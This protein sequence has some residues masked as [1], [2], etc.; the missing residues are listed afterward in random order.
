MEVGVDI[1]LPFWW[2]IK[3][4][5][6]GAWEDAKVRF[7]S[8]DCLKNYTKYEQAEF[9]LTWDEDVCKNPEARIVGYVSMVQNN[10]ENQ[11]PTK[12]HRYLDIMGKDLADALPKHRAYDCR[13]HLKEGRTAPWGPI[14]PLS[15][16]ELQT[17]REWLKE[18]EKTA[19][20]HHSTS[21]AGSPILFV[22]KPNRRGLRLCVDHRRLN[23]ITILNRYL[24]PLM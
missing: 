1:F 10:E 5:P 7:N 9:S 24:L 8:S 3:H 12:F 15:E 19:K 11:V 2:I 17:L 4:P 13:I 22:P 18:M 20:I 23:Q 6:Q 21:L 14:Y 16:T